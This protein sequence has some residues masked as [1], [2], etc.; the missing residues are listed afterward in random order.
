MKINRKTVRDY[1]VAIV[2]QFYTGGNVVAKRSYTPKKEDT[3][4]VKIYLIEGEPAN[5]TNDG[6]LVDQLAVAYLKRDAKSDDELDIV[7]DQIIK[8]FD[9]NH[10]FDSWI[11]GIDYD[12]YSYPDESETEYPSI[13]LNFTVT[14]E[15]V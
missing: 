5:D 9:V 10:N 14:R 3:E 7:A 12:G 13:V 8:A 11:H 6:L 15:G 2:A 1:A 4:L